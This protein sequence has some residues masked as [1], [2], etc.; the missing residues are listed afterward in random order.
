MSVFSSFSR[1]SRLSLRISPQRRRK[2]LLDMANHVSDP[3]REYKVRF[4]SS[5]GL[6]LSA[7]AADVVHEGEGLCEGDE[8]FITYGAHSNAV[9][10]L[11]VPCF[12]ARAHAKRTKASRTLLITGF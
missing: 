8:V 4:T 10:D 3:S 11:L 1:V 7:P 5:G 9:R 12:C 2:A 6:E